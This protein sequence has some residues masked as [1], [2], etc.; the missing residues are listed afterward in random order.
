MSEIYIKGV[1]RKGITENS[2]PNENAGSTICQYNK[3]FFRYSCEDAK[4]HIQKNKRFQVILAKTHDYNIYRRFI[5][6]NMHK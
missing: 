5:Y 3:R 6:A 4:E 1:T 2:Q